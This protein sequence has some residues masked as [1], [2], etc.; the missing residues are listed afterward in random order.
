MSYRA[1]MTERRLSTSSM[2]DVRTY[3]EPIVRQMGNPRISNSNTS[4]AAEAAVNTRGF[5]AWQKVIETDP[6][7]PVNF[8]QYWHSLT[9][10]DAGATEGSIRA[11]MAMSLRYIPDLMQLNS[12]Q[13]IGFRVKNG[14]IYNYAREYLDTLV[15]EGMIVEMQVGPNITVNPSHKTALYK[16]VNDM[17]LP[18]G[19]HFSVSERIKNN[20]VYQDAQKYIYITN[21]I[22]DPEVYLRMSTAIAN[23]YLP[24][25][26]EKGTSGVDELLTLIRE[27]KFKEIGQSL[28]DAA[29]EALKRLLTERKNNALARL[30]RIDL[31]SAEISRVTNKLNEHK[32]NIQSYEEILRRLYVDMQECERLLFALTQRQTTSTLEEVVE[33]LRTVDTLQGV[34]PINNNTMLGICVYGP[35]QGMDTVPI[36]DMIESHRQD[37]LFYRQHEWMQDLIK[38]I[39][40]DQDV[41]IYLKTAGTMKLIPDREKTLKYSSSGESYAFDRPTYYGLAG[42]QNP[43]HSLHNCWGTYEQEVSSALRNKDYITATAM[44]VACLTQVN[45]SDSIVL[46][47]FF[48]Q[49][50]ETTYKVLLVNGEMIS[51]ETYRYRF[52][53]RTLWPEQQPIATV[54]EPVDTGDDIPETEPTAAPF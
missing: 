19:M 23:D 31:N 54:L 34:A 50:T 5:W 27:E 30:Q 28:M 7:N 22:S 10:S 47:Q 18:L 13:L 12:L 17:M 39:Y 8:Q 46:K 14:V 37:N 52:E 24:I 1:D 36:V 33:F 45:T 42:M 44:M 6:A 3:F 32:D 16:I 40:I 25:M 51:P 48:E 11:A 29:A 53:N 35:M 38:H 43:H 20:A 2:N 21:I 26:K 49:I 15:R 41:K 4:A 9:Q